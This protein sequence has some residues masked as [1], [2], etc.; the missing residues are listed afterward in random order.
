[1]ECLYVPVEEVR[2]VAGEARLTLLSLSSGRFVITADAAL[3]LTFLG[4]LSTRQAYTALELTVAL[5]ESDKFIVEP[6]PRE[7][8]RRLDSSCSRHQIY[9]DQGLARSINLLPQF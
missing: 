1:V 8:R 7:I 3:L 6:D 4:R 2:I 9:D 5:A